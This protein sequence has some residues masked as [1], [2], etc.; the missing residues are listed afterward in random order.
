MAEMCALRFSLRMTV[1]CLVS[2]GLGAIGPAA[3]TATGSAIGQRQHY[4]G[5]VNGKHAQAVI[6][7]VC[8]GPAGGHRTGP[9]AGHQTV[10]VRRVT[11]GGGYTGS[12]ARRIW[13]EFGRDASN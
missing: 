3:A 6:Y 8:P 2:I 11:V 9:P 7:V 10:A 12:K 5:L 1:C 4:L 13:A